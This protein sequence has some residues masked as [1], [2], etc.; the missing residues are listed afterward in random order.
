MP[1]TATISVAQVVLEVLVPT[2]G[3]PVPPVPPAPTPQTIVGMGPPSILCPRRLNIYDFC[4][5]GEKWRMK[6]ICVERPCNIPTNL[7]AWEEDGYPTPAGAVPF[8]IVNS[9]PTPLPAAGDVLVC[10]GKVPL[11]YDGLLTEI[12]QFFQGGGFQQGS[13][14][15]IWRIRRNQ[16]WLKQLGNCIYSLGN[17]QNPISLTEGQILFSG[18]QFGFY[19][20]APNVTGSLIIAGSSV[21][22]GMRGFYWPRG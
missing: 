19:V 11:G 7:L 16:I 20:N 18:T 22:C 6:R 21:V 14:D 8:H 4:A 15:L 13:G 10:S 17:P 9:I 5:L 3:A 12:F 2:V 1:I